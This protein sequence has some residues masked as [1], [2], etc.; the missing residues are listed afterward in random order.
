MTNSRAT[1]KM[2]VNARK[3]PQD[4]FRKGEACP[5]QL[6]TSEVEPKPGSSYVEKLP[7]SRGYQGRLAEAT[8]PG[9]TQ[10]A[11][12]IKPAKEVPTPDPEAQSVRNK[13]QP[14]AGT[15]PHK[16]PQ[17]K[18]AAASLHSLSTRAGTQPANAPILR[19]ANIVPTQ[20]G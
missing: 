12:I 16:P 19:G 18:K 1:A 20:L 9:F 11:E 8:C 3:H 7:G 15:A 14:T 2:V 4:L 5:N 17:A 13:P 10:S 6:C